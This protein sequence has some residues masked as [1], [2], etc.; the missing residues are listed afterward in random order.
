MAVPK[1]GPWLADAFAA[2]CQANFGTLVEVLLRPGSQKDFLTQHSVCSACALPADTALGQV[3][4]LLSA[5][6]ETLRM[7]GQVNLRDRQRHGFTH[8][9]TYVHA[10]PAGPMRNVA[11]PDAE[12][13][14]LLPIS[15]AGA[16][17]RRTAIF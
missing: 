2:M 6:R 15:E 1:L 9:D 10:P 16:C 8:T 4:L 3:C 13:H 11:E 14:L 12:E 5:A 7:V 17:C